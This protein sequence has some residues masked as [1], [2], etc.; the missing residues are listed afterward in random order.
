MQGAGTLTRLVFTLLLLC[1]LFFLLGTIDVHGESLA[2]CPML[3]PQLT[4]TG[5][6]LKYRAQ[7][8]TGSLGPRLFEDHV[9]T[10]HS[11]V[12]FCIQT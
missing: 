4:G 2:G 12:I 6:K 5:P 1:G 9:C 11:C 8:L 10:D 7:T 3:L